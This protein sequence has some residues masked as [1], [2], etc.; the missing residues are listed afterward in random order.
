MHMFI[1]VIITLLINRSRRCSIFIITILITINIIII[2]MIFIIINI[3]II[4][5]LIMPLYVAIT[6]LLTKDSP[7]SMFEFI[8]VNLV[9]I[10]L[11]DALLLNSAKIISKVNGFV[12][13]ED[14]EFITEVT[15]N[16][17]VLC[18]GYLRD[19]T[20]LYLSVFLS[21]FSICSSFSLLL[22]FQFRSRN[23]KQKDRRGYFLMWTRSTPSDALALS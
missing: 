3:I 18:P 10:Y 12:C 5:I 21:I 23:K 17:V 6:K 9:F 2:I 22:P 8:A 1:D 16:G 7:H 20:V 4:V 14:S 11:N 13:Y 15:R 19:C